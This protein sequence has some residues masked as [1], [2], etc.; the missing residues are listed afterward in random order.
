MVK[1][2]FLKSIVLLTV[3]AL[4]SCEDD[5]AISCVTCNSPETTAFEVCRDQNGNATVNGENTDTN[6]DVYI[7]GLEE[8]GATCGGG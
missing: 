4:F 3:A 8:S 1:K 6:Y 2:Y 7:A 5:P